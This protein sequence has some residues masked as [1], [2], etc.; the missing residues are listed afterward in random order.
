MCTL[1]STEWLAERLEAAFVF[2]EFRTAARFLRRN[3]RNVTIEAL[4]EQTSRKIR[5]VRAYV[6]RNP[7][8]MRYLGIR[9]QVSFEHVYEARVKDRAEYERVLAEI[10]G[11]YNEAKKAAKA[12]EKPVTAEVVAKFAHVA[13]W[14]VRSF[15]KTHPKLFSLN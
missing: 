7:K 8:R 9:I 5:E 4:A 2:E 6:F 15:E 12:A 10:A 1:F 14:Q 11:R 3:G 13:P